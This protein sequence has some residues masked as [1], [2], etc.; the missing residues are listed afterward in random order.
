MTSMSNLYFVPTPTGPSEMTS[1]AITPVIHLTL[2]RI[3]ATQ[4]K[5]SSMGQLMVMAV[6]IFAIFGY[7]FGLN[8]LRRFY[9]FRKRLRRL[10]WFVVSLDRIL[11]RWQGLQV[12][13]DRLQ[14]VVGHLR[15]VLPGHAHA[16]PLV[17]SH[18]GEE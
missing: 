8:Q 6:S 5:T 15:K 13:V 12:Q 18:R 10:V 14:F 3:S 9:S 11:Q 17:C 4:A 7:P 16:I 2:L 1:A